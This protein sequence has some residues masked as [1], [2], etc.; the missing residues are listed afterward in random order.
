MDHSRPNEQ[1]ECITVPNDL[2]IYSDED[3]NDFEEFL[4][5]SYSPV[6]DMSL[7]FLQE[8]RDRLQSVTKNI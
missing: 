7:T 8:T 4:D 3:E 6:S 5:N 2:P 1:P